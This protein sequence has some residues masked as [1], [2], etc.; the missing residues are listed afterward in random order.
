MPQGDEVQVI[1][2]EIEAVDDPVVARSQA[3]LP[4]PLEPLMKGVRP[5]IGSLRFWE[6]NQSMVEPL[7]ISNIPQI[8]ANGRKR[9]GPQY[10]LCAETASGTMGSMLV[11]GAKRTMLWS[12]SFFS[13]GHKYPF[14]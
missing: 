10:C 12:N 6:M 5:W 4:T 13:F 14:A 8:Q 9:T 11:Q 3:K 2:L 1:P 7:F